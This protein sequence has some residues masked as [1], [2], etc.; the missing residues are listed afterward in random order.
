MQ[1]RPTST[2]IN[3]DTKL[4]QI[5]RDHKPTEDI[6]HLYADI[7]RLCASLGEHQSLSC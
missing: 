4:H 3:G 1:N 2:T 7:H 5:I 6:K